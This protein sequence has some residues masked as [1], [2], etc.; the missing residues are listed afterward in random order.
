M[1]VLVDTNIFLN[2]AREEREFLDGSEELLKRIRREE[3]EGLASCIVLIEIKWA[4][5][6]K[7]EF[8]KADKAVS[9]I[10]ELVEI[11]PVDKETAKEAIEIKIRKR[12]ELLD[13]IHVAT[14]ILQEAILVTRD[15]DIR[16]RCEDI[17][18]IRTPEEIL[19]EKK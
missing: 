9:L 14:A 6:E 3:I 18:T 1:R 15:I 2:V 17:V 19:E 16:K 8:A 4:L 11:A 12:L 13:S 10:E 5:Y 7:G